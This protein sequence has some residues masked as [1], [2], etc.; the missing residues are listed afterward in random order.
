M[1]IANRDKGRYTGA[2]EYVISR[3]IEYKNKADEFLMKRAHS[4]YFI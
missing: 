2:D 3:L 1:L 4:C